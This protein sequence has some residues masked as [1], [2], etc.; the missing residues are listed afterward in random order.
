MKFSLES[1]SDINEIISYDDDHIVIRPRNNSELLR[2][3]TN[4]ILTPNKIVQN[5]TL[6]SSVEQ[7]ELHYLKTLEPEVLILTQVTGLPVSPQVL[8]KFSEHSIG[9]ESMP[10]GAACRTYNLLANEGRQ[11]VFVVSFT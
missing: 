8:V 10:L 3:D 2:L 1:R 11:V 6:S 4:L 7:D 5:R 9:V